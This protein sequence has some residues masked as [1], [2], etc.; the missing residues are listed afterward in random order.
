M[1]LLDTVKSS[2]DNNCPI[3]NRIT[4]TNKRCQLRSRFSRKIPHQFDFVLSA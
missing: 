4:T 2:T 3:N 1:Q